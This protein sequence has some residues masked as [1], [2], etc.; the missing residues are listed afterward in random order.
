METER[1]KS[2]ALSK[3]PLPARDPK[4]RRPRG[5]RLLQP[6]PVDIT[7]GESSSD[8]GRRTQ[9]GSQLLLPAISQER[10]EK[11]LELHHRVAVAISQAMPEYLREGDRVVFEG[12][13]FLSFREV[14]A[15]SEAGSLSAILHL[16]NPDVAGLAIANAELN[17]YFAKT[18]IGT[19]KRS[20]S[21]DTQ[22]P[23]SRLEMAIA[24]RAMRALIERFGAFYREAGVGI[25]RCETVGEPIASSAHFEADE[26]LLVLRL[27]FGSDEPVKRLTIATGVGLLS[28]F[29]TERVTTASGSE[30]PLPARAADVPMTASIVLGSWNIRLTDL[31]ELRVGDE[32]VLPEG[33][34]AWLLG[35]GVRLQRVRLGFTHDRVRASRTEARH[36]GS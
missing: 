5:R 16:E 15:G 6:S 36:H 25:L 11:I 22:L 28:A 33:D 9:Q 27:R 7:P 18:V 32:I 2:S 20:G 8:A 23:L 12:L 10:R 31:T 14:S 26:C 29:R 35:S 24:G 30:L 34:D 3:D 13:N 17:T 1:T 21:A 19:E 4:Q